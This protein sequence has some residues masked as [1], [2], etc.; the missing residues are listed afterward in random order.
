MFVNF[1]IAN[2][3]PDNVYANNSPNV[4]LV[5]RALIVSSN[6]DKPFTLRYEGGET[7]T[8]VTTV[9][10]STQKYE[11]SGPFLNTNAGKDLVIEFSSALESP[12]AVNV[13]FDIQRINI[14]EV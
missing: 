5:V 9:A 14:P 6:T 10:G 1:T 12:D 4:V 7:I 8:T 13:F 2:T 11:I 3:F